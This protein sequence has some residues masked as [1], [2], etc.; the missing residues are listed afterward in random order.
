[1]QLLANLALARY[2]LTPPLRQGGLG[3]G[4]EWTIW[5]GFEYA[6]GFARGLNR[7]AEVCCWA[8]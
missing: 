8:F 6:V 7:N 5:S 3:F 4:S 2:T 1:M